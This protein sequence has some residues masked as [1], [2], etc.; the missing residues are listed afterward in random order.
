LL[1]STPA[2]EVC[3]NPEAVTVDTYAG[4]A[5]LV[6][7]DETEIPVRATLYVVT[8]RKQVPTWQGQIAGSEDLWNVYQEQGAK[9]RMSD[10]REGDVILMSYAASNPTTVVVQGIGPPPF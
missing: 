8:S 2:G 1:I 6:T 7:Q 4:P 10:G 5:I 3:P 9:L